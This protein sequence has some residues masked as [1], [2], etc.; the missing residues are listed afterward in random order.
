MYIVVLCPSICRYVCICVCTYLYVCVCVRM[1][2]ECMYM[3]VGRGPEGLLLY[4]YASDGGLFSVT[5]KRAFPPLGTGT[6][7]PHALPFGSWGV[8]SVV[9]EGIAHTRQR[10]THSHTHSHEWIQ[11]ASAWCSDLFFIIRFLRCYCGYVAQ[12]FSSSSC[13]FAH[14]AQISSSLSDSWGATMGCCVSCIEASW[15][16]LGPASHLHLDMIHPLSS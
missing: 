3:H 8:Q 5:G 12:I 10:R 9:R 4:V 2:H 11:I 6:R 16:F 14:D 13:Y 7:R 1:M 15:E